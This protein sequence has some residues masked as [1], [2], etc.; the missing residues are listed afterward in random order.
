MLILA[1]LPILF[2]LFSIFW[3]F[4]DPQ[5]DFREAIIKGSVAGGLVIVGITELL[6][7]FKIINFSA[8]GVLWVSVFAVAAISSRKNLLKLQIRPTLTTMKSWESAV[9]LSMIFILSVVG[10]LTFYCPPNNFDALTYHLSR[11]EH[12]VQNQTLAHFP[13]ND[14][15]Q[16][17]SNPFAEMVILHF[18]ILTDS[19]LFSNSI[20]F[21]ALIGCLIGATLLAARM[22]IKRKGQWLTAIF[23]LTIPMAILQGSSAQ[24]DLVVS[25]FLLCFTVFLVDWVES[26]KLQDCSFMALSLGL[27]IL[28]KGTAYMFGLPFFVFIVIWAFKRHWQQFLA[29]MLFIALLILAPIAG[30]YSRNFSFC[31]APM[32]SQAGIRSEANL[33]NTISNIIKVVAT[34]FSTPSLAINENIEEGVA[35]LHDLFD[36]KPDTRKSHYL[37]MSFYLLFVPFHEDVAGNPLH[38]FAIMLSLLFIFFCNPPINYESSPAENKLNQLMI[39]KFHG[40]FLLA[41]GLIFSSAIL[42]QPWLTRLNLPLLILSAPLVG[43]TFSYFHR[44]VLI[45]IIGFAFVQALPV[46]FINTRKPIL[47]KEILRAYLPAF[48]QYSMQFKSVIELSRLENFLNRSQLPDCQKITTYLKTKG[49]SQIGL[50]V[51]G[52]WPEYY[53]WALMREPGKSLRI[54]HVQLENPDMPG[55]FHSGPFHPSCIISTRDQKE[56]IKFASQIFTKTRLDFSPIYIYERT[57]N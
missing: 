7:F 10:F 47:G 25:F 30:H 3:F 50:A 21:F 17:Y 15:R 35:L 46:L 55:A 29:T 41:G 4:P 54:E 8:L 12:W 37:N 49:H 27:A 44:Y 31:G 23:C 18:R 42:W 5:K 51:N 48:V 36:L 53:L 34:N 56:I 9:L 14:V 52:N 32:G 43:F 1:A 19:D 11:V 45:A 57:L 38:I 2:F 28:T 16:L 24:N 39:L 20:Q 40:L 6:S 22:R 13:T 26:G 33:T